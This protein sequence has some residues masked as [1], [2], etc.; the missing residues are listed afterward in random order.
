MTQG[1]YVRANLCSL[2]SIKNA[3]NDMVTEV[4]MKDLQLPCRTWP[5]TVRL[6]FSFLACCVAGF[7]QLS[8]QADLLKKRGNL[9]LCVLVFAV[10]MSVVGFIHYGIEKSAYLLLKPSRKLPATHVHTEIGSCA[11]DWDFFTVTFAHAD[12]DLKHAARFTLTDYFDEDGV[13]LVR[14]FKHDLRNEIKY[15]RRLSSK[16]D[17]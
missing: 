2:T 4:L 6:L 9:Q 5:S 12:S 1:S 10:F 15:F 16:K 7:A 13:M 14:K 8:P 11:P 3:M 17:L